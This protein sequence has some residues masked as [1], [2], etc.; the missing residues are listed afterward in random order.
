MPCSLDRDGDRRALRR[1]LLRPRPA[2]DRPYRRRALDETNGQVCDGLLRA[3]CQGRLTIFRERA[4]SRKALFAPGESGEPLPPGRQVPG[5]PSTLTLPDLVAKRGRTRP[6]D[7][8][9]ARDAP[10]RGRA[11]RAV[12]TAAIHVRFRAVLPRVG[13][14]LGLTL[15]ALAQRAAA[16]ARFGA[17]LARRA[18]RA[19]GTAAIH[20]R[21]GA[22]LHPIDAAS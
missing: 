3:N 1:G 20:V 21:L 5:T 12:R 8:V 18:R 22:A 13:A 4:R 17:R 2:R 14:V 16:V 9:T 7:A 15:I 6:A 11:S 19:V 10:G